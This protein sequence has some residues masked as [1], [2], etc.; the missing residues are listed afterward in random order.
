[1]SPSPNPTPEPVALPIAI[2]VYPLT[3]KDVDRK[4]KRIR[5]LWRLPSEVIIFDTETRTD[6]KQSITFGGYRCILRGKFI[7]EGLF[8]GNNLT[9]RELSTLRDYVKSHRPIG[10]DHYPPPLRLR[11]LP[12]FLEQ[13]LFKDGYKWK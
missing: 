10:V 6:P 4:Q 7:E 1:L 9:R 11:S 2:R 5:K 3:A 12:E 8:Y 13:F